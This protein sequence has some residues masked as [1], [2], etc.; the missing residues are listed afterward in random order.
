[1]SEPV[2]ALI[3]DMDGTLV[4]NMGVHGEAW[5]AWHDREGLPFDADAFFA[6]TAGR[7]NAEII[8]ALYPERGAEGI[9]ALGEAKE[10]VY[11]NIYGPR[12]RAVDGLLDLL[13]AAERR[14]LRLAV[15]TAAPP[16]NIALV[17][18]AL[19][20][21]ARF[22]AVVS[23]ALGLRGKAH[24]DIFLHAAQQLGV[25]PS[26]CLVFEDAP[27]GVEAARRAGMR[28]VALTTTLGPGDFAA[29]DNVVE[30]RPDF[31]GFDLD[32]PRLAPAAA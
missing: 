11:R 8:A 16:S 29:F 1:V 17:L 31:R 24:P 12:V 7:T 26:R 19:S 22:E 3:F 23:P 10:A 13:D 25:P 28:V 9:A 27:L 4:D 5:G 21:R 15:A 30:T 32:A 2:E 18:D 20:L 6:R 14:G